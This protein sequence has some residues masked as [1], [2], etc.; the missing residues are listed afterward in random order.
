M[1]AWNSHPAPDTRPD[2]PGPCACGMKVLTRWGTAHD[3]ASASI[4]F[5]GWAAPRRHVPPT[6]PV[7]AAARHRNGR[8]AGVGT[9]RGTR[10]RWQHALDAG[11]RHRRCT[12]DRVEP[13]DHHLA[14]TVAR[15]RRPGPRPGGEP[16]HRRADRPDGP[17]RAGCRVDGTEQRLGCGDPRWQSPA[18]RHPARR[19]RRRPCR[20]GKGR[21]A[22]ASNDC[23]KCLVRGPPRIGPWC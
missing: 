8:H 1:T 5:S 10:Q 21:Q 11:T 2:R 17:E 9:T 3:S 7:P 4:G 13:H 14:R 6:P 22:G 20:G 23:A 19:C 18:V 15:P 12:G 16:A